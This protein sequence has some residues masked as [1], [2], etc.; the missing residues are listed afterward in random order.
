MQSPEAKRCHEK[1]TELIEIVG[2]WVFNIV[3]N[4]ESMAEKYFCLCLL[5]MDMGLCLYVYVIQFEREIIVYLPVC[6]F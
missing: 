3:C 1:Y 4:T 5:D 2:A 6:L